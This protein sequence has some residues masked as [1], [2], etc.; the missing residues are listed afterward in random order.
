MAHK[1][2]RRQTGNIY[3][4]YMYIKPSPKNV[5]K[6]APIFHS[7]IFHSPIFS[8]PFSQLIADGWI[9]GRKKKENATI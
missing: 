3:N 9:K 8:A 7:C 1:K 2:R 4:R 6:N 5:F